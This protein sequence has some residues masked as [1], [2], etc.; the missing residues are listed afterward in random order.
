MGATTEPVSP[1]EPVEPS[2]S[3]LSR[4]IGVFFSPGPTFEDIA[5]K[6]GFWAPLIV[7]LVSGLAMAE[8]MVF[9]IG[10]ERLIRMS[11]EQ[12][13]QA[14][15]MS[16]EQIENVIRTWSKIGMVTTPLTIV[17]GLPIFL[18]IL[19]AIGLAIVNFILGG[20]IGFKKAFSAAC[21]ANVVGVVGSLMGIALILFGDPENFNAQNPIPS[22]LGFFLNPLDT[23]KVVLALANSLDIVTI[24]MVILFSLGISKATGGK[25]KALSIFLCVCGVWVVYIL[26]KIG[27]VMIFNR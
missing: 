20:Q 7:I 12:G 16:P 8:A 27:W 11:L 23:S 9:K 3:T 26:G 25:Q 4:L 10:M 1:I 24:W 18:L 14:Q 5:R 22:N 17:L 6:P 2:Q 13:G 21:Y 19:A 15:K